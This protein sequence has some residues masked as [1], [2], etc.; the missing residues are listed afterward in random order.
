[1]AVLLVVLFHADEAV[2]GGSY[3]V[4]IFF[5]LSGY[6]ITRLL[7]AERDATGR[8]DYRRFFVRRARR[9]LPALL[10]VSATWALISGS[11]RDTL[12]ALLYVSNYST[13]SGGE[14]TPLHHTWSL[15]VEEHFYLIW[16]FLIGLASARHRSRIL[17]G[18]LAASVIWRAFV[19]SAGWE[20]WAYYSTDAN[21]VAI[22]AGCAV[23]VLPKWPRWV[24]G[25]WAPLVLLLVTTVVSHRTAAYHWLWFAVVAVAAVAVRQAPQVRWLELPPLRWFGTISYGLYLWHYPLIRLMAAPA[26]SVALSVTLAA[27]MW[28]SVE[29]PVL[30]SAAVTASRPLPSPRQVGARRI[31]KSSSS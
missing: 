28:Y 7:A 29:R 16:P 9:L 14:W 11:W 3:G 23:A 31:T 21:S 2:P 1:M 18:L 15:A 5:V 8:V 24:H 4:T 6:L 19:L 30:R 27:V 17:G 12:P 20:R 13:L 25:R 10:I 26:A 22:L